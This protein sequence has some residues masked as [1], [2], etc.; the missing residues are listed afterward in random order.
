[1]D[2]ARYV[3]DAVV[4]EGRSYRE[5]AR[6]HG[7]SK[8]WVGKLVGR[9]RTGGYPPDPAEVPGRQAHPA[10]Q[11]IGPLWLACT[12]HSGHDAGILVP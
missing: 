5:V 4:V 6:A 8:S 1:M 12:R 7:V 2:L 10:T 3:V 11:V 9:F